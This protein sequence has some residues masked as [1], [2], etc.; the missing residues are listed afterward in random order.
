MPM[1]KNS[2]LP[3]KKTRFTTIPNLPGTSGNV[4]HVNKNR[5]YYCYSLLDILQKNHC[6]LLFSLKLSNILFFIYNIS[7]LFHR[8]YV[9]NIQKSFLQAQ[10]LAKGRFL[11]TYPEKKHKLVID[12]Q[13]WRIQL[14]EDRAPPP[15]H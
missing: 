15:P 8:A 4:G 5:N 12:L 13:Q 14:W 1:K 11:Q 7:C 10:Q 3:V 6:G 2:M 9:T